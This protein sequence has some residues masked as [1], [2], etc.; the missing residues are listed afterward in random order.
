MTEADVCEQVSPVLLQN[1]LNAS[2]TF[3]SQVRCT[4]YCFTRPKTF[5][6]VT[7][8]AATITSRFWL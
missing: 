4:N 8:C 3:L 6:N 2:T 1:G 7:K 5:Q